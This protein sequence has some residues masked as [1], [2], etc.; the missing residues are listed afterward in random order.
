LSRFLLRPLEH[1]EITTMIRTDGEKCRSHRCVEIDY[2]ETGPTAGSTAAAEP[3]TAQVT[4]QPIKLLAEVIV[5]L[6]NI[7]LLSLVT[8]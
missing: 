7:A 1:L 6:T 5:D 4:W 2:Y 3:T 8:F